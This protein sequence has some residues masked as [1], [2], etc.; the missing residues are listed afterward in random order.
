MNY[1][2]NNYHYSLYCSSV[3]AH[4]QARTMVDIHNH[5]ENHSLI[6]RIK[7]KSV[8]FSNPLF[9]S[10]DNFTSNDEELLSD[11][12]VPDNKVKIYSNPIF[13]YHDEY[14]SSDENPLFDEVLK[15]IECKDSYDP[16]LDES[17]FLVT[18][19]S[20]GYILYLES[21]LNDDLVH[22]DLSIP[23]MS[24]AS[25]F[26][27]FTDELPLKENDDLFDLEPKNDDWKKILYDAPILMTGDKVFEPEIHDQN[28]SP[29]YVSLPFEDRH[30]LFFTYVVR[31]L[32]LYFTYLVVSPFLI[33]FGSE[34]TIFDPGISAFHFSHRSGTFISFHVYP[35]ILNESPV[36]NFPSTCFTPNITMIW[37]E[38]S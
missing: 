34:D 27:G 3:P 8:T 35:N 9:N 23:A 12:D 14:I 10:N 4:R 20:A 18:P 17:T 26:E 22:R 37:G 36:K 32:L 13:K 1:V 24:V 7:E 38:S 28:L 30:Y 11:E 6:T 5:S 2:D 25:I 31:I 21:F 33:S 15:D 29:T 16:N 19:L